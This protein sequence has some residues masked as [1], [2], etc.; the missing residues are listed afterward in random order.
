VAETLAV[1]FVIRFCGGAVANLIVSAVEAVI[2]MVA[3]DVEDEFAV[4]DAVIVTFAGLPPGMT[5]GAV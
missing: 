5:D 4:D 1:A 2:V 3:A